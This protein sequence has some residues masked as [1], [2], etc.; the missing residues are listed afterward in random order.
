M[1]PPPNGMQE[2][3]EQLET[4][5]KTA[6]LSASIDDVQKTID[7]LT[8]ARARIANGKCPYRVLDGAWLTV[9]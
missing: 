2:L 3:L 9:L 8:A 5:E 7:L 1:A 6:N 4:L